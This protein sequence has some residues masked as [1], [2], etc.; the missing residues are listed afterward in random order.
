MN[1]TDSGEYQRHFEAPECWRRTC[2]VLHIEKS[3]VSL[4]EKG[5]ERDQQVLVV[6]SLVG[7]AK[8]DAVS[9]KHLSR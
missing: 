8:A 1:Q 6:T 9:S 3:S 5:T 7:N 2:W 4:W